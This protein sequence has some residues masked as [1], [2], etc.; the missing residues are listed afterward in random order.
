MQAHSDLVRLAGKLRSFLG[1]GAIGF[2]V[3]A[4]VFF[5]MTAALDLSYVWAR[6]TASLI[7]LTATFFLNRSVTFADGRI[8]P[9]AIEFMR[10]MGASA[11]GAFANLAVLT[12]I[13]PYDEALRHVPAYIAGAAAGLIVNFMTYDRFVFRGRPA[14]SSRPACLPENR[15]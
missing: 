15:P 5:C 2:L 3:D 10:Y 13:A 14:P 9:V 1:V 4:L 6:L 8:D 12:L 7:A 11:L